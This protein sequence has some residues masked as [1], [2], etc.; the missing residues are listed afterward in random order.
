MHRG[1]DRKPV[2][3]AAFPLARNKPDLVERAETI[4]KSIR[5]TFRTVYDEGNVGQLYRQQDE[6]GTPP[7]IV[8]DLQSLDD[9]GFKVRDRDSMLQNRVA[10]DQLT[11]Y[12]TERSLSSLVVGRRFG[13]TPEV[14]DRIRATGMR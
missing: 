13:L 12:L 3:A 11:A 6:I 4:R 2:Q 7:C 5:P 14:I 10:Q 9:H 8:V 1:P